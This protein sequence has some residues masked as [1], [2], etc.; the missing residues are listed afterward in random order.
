[1]F[2][3]SMMPSNHHIVCCPLLLLPSITPSIGVFSKELASLIKWPKYWSFSFSISP[4]NEYSG[5]ISFRMDW[6][7]LLAVQGTLKSLLQHHTSKASILQ[8]SAF[9]M[10]R[11]SHLCLTTGKTIAL[12][13]QTFVDKV[14]SLLFNMLSRLLIAFLPRI[15]EAGKS[16]ICRMGNKQAADLEGQ[17]FK[18]RATCWKDPLLFWKTQLI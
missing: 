6:F 8:H 9:F 5:L 18:L 17:Q 13:I 4:S 12:T 10:V 11:L 2:I 14:M 1:M 15:A 16:K 7:A 3:E